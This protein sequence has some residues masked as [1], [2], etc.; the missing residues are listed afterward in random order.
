MCVMGVM[1]M[2]NIVH[3]VGIEPISLAMLANVLNITPRKL[4]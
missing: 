1:K 4:P 2:G 3:R